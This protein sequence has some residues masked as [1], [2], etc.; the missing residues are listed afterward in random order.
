MFWVCAGEAEGGFC[1]DTSFARTCDEDCRV[2]RLRLGGWAG[3]LTCLAANLAGECVDD[4]IACGG[5]AEGHCCVKHS[6]DKTKGNNSYERLL[7]DQM[8]RE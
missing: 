4:F 2:V 3:R 8:V 5:E 6:K 7:D 1:T